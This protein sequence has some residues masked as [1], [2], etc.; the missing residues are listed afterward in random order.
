MGETIKDPLMK[1]QTGLLTFIVKQQS[2][3]TLKLNRTVT[4]TKRQL[5]GEGKYARVR[6][7]N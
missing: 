2:V 5:V 4:V 6:M 1:I 3:V 7:E